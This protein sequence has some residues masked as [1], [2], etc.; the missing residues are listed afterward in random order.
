M[1]AGVYVLLLIIFNI[2]NLK[3]FAVATITIVLVV[4]VVLVAVDAT[5]YQVLSVYVF[6]LSATFATAC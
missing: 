1:T 3:K 5:K 2:I 4:L 6:E